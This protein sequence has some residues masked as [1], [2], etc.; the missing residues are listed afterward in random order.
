LSSGYSS[1]VTWGNTLAPCAGCHASAATLS[2]GSHS[3][4]L[5]V[6]NVTCNYCHNATASSN[7]AISNV[8]NHVDKNASINFNATAAPAAGAYN[9]QTAGGATVYQKPVGTAAGRCSNVTCHAN[10]YG[11]GTV[12]TPT[13]GN[14]TD[15]TACHT[16]AIGATGPATGSHTAHVGV[17]C[18]QCHNVGTTA[19]TSP[20]THHA[21]GNI[22]I[23][24]V[25]YPASVTK[26]AS[27]T[28]YST[29]SASTCHGPSSPVWGTNLSTR[30]TC[31][32]C[33]GTLT[34]SGIITAAANNRYLVAPPTG[35]G[36]VTGTLTGTGQVSNNTKVGAHQTHLRYFNGFSNY[37]TVDFLCTNC[38]GTLP[39]S[40]SHANGSSAPA[41]QGMANNRGA[42]T[43]TWSAA[44]FTC[45][46]TYCHNPAGTGG[47]LAAAN[48]GVRP[49][50]SWTASSYL[51]V[52]STKTQANCNRCHKVPEDAGF[53]STY[54]HGSMPTSTACT[55]C[56]EHEGNTAGTAGRRHMDGIKYGG[57]NC[58][59]CHGYQ[60]GTWAAKAERSG[61]PE[62]KG[63]HEKHIAYL[64]AR[65]S[66][67]LN[68]AS[69]QFGSAAA[70]WTNVCGVCHNGATHSTGEG[71]PGTGRTISIQPAYWF[72][73]GTGTPVY[74]GIVGVSSATTAKTCSNVS[75]HYLT[76]PLWSTY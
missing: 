23:V 69:D 7:S 74:S 61:V 50:V 20:T 2:T 10:V 65:Y 55:P 42:M 43:P 13:W 35:I 38:H 15:C 25:G 67:T 63:A 22:D 70:S 75:C 1:T 64:T 57:G 19:S 9:G 18:T 17:L 36:G 24:G 45:S 14:V 27:G 4:H 71:I 40:G 60:V 32:K 12:A 29:C 8:A 44:T 28:G 41:F 72:G 3:A 39:V 37:S 11:T 34:N 33:H 48:V 62:G 68:P 52:A 58:D 66:V 31:T 16:I 30:D 59:A 54:N 5:A 21:D 6:A 56:H 47:K 46:N 53:S 73:P 51:D 26:H 76:T 49:F